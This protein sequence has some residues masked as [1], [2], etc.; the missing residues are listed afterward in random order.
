MCYRPTNTAIEEG[1]LDNIQPHPNFDQSIIMILTGTNAQ[2][3]DLAVTELH[4]KLTIMDNRTSKLAPH[5]YLTL[6]N[7]F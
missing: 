5:K 4:V 2:F 6:V 1:H 3:V 7:N